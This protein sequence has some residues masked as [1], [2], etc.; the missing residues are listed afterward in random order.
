MRPQL[1]AVDVGEEV[2]AALVELLDHLLDAV[3]LEVQHP[4]EL[5][6]LE[7]RLDGLDLV[8][9]LLVVQVL[10]VPLRDLVVLQLL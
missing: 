5:L 4:L 1:V 8:V 3:A 10:R 2:Y 6:L 7:E 9:Q